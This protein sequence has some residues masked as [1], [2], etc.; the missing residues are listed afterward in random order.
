[1]MTY[2]WVNIGSGKCLLPDGTKPFSEPMLTYHQSGYMAFTKGIF[3]GN[4]KITLIKMSLNT[5]YLK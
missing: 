1:M 4:T 2:I 5:A 3:I